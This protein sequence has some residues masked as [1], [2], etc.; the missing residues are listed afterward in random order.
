MP[1]FKLTEEHIKVMTELNFMTAVF[2]DSS[3]RFIPTIDRKRPFG[4]SGATTNVCEIMK[5]YGN[6]NGEYSAEV[7]N[8][9]ETLLIELPVALQIVMQNHTFEPGEYEVEE[10]SS[11]YFNY[12]H[13]RNY[14]ALKETLAEVEKKC[15]GHPSLKRLH[16]VCMNV[17]GDDPWKVIDDL[18]FFNDYDG[19]IADAIKIFEKHR[20]EQ[21]LEEWLGTHDGEDYCKYC[22]ENDDCPHGMACYGGE[23][24]EPTCYG[25]DMKELLYTDSIVED[26]LEE[27]YGKEQ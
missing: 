11:A 23:P 25:A 2:V 12:I 13:M 1:K 26:V 8:K 18:K 20:D 3:D 16:E 22:P 15:E 21:I 14:H 27:R 4:N 5:W 7:I 19:F 10:Y 24:I 9:A 6:E 17:F